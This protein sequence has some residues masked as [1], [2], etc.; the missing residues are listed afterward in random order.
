MTF[1]LYPVV[2][3]SIPEPIQQAIRD[4]NALSVAINGR[5]LRDDEYAVSLPKVAIG[6][7]IA[8]KTSD[9]LTLHVRSLKLCWEYFRCEWKDVG[10]LLGPNFTEVPQTPSPASAKMR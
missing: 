3:V 8:I 4:G 10:H 9:Y 6:V 2:E 7:P 5:F 1:W